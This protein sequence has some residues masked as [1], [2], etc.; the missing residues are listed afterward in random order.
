MMDFSCLVH[1]QCQH[2]NSARP[3][4]L[5]CI[6]FSCQYLRLDFSECCRIQRA[7]KF[8]IEALS[9]ATGVATIVGR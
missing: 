7:A 6:I 9:R 4:P 8:Q 2:V 1:V 3:L 5:E